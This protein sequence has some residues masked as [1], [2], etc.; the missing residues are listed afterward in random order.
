M[1][2]DDLEK[3]DGGT[4]FD[5]LAA[6]EGPIDREQPMEEQG[7]EPFSDEVEPETPD[8]EP[9]QVL[10]QAE[11]EALIRSV[12]GS[13]ARDDGGDMTQELLDER[14]EEARNKGW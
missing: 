5:A 14:R 11:R 1:K 12:M 13:L 7:R 4:I 10:T 8:A 6:V 3:Q 2:L 9:K